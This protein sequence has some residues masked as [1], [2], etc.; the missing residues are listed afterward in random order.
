MP[1]F[2]KWLCNDV[3][4]WLRWI[5][6]LTT[7]EDASDFH[8]SHFSPLPSHQSPLLLERMSP[9]GK[10]NE[11][12]FASETKPSEDWYLGRE[13]LY[14][15]WYLRL[16]HLIAQELAKLRIIEMFDIIVDYPDSLAALED[17]KEC[18]EKTDQK[19][20]LAKTLK[21]QLSSRLLH[22]GVTTSDILA[23]YV[24]AIHSL[25]IADPDGNVL[26][27]ISKPVRKYLQNRSDTIRCIIHGITNETEDESFRDLIS[28][29][30]NVTED[31]EEA[32]GKNFC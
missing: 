16:D 18:L 32:L 6:G 1:F 20:V 25:R 22:A 2:N 24:H 15:Q 19:R 4:T 10:A 11:V 26:S 8:L 27:Y 9:T 12:H 5:L 29:A 7:K 3:L 28:V 23:T 17:L 30:R 21:L 14:T 13:K 31:D